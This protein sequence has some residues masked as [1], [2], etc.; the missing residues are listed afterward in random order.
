MPK[1]KELTIEQKLKLLTGKNMWQTEDFE[2]DID[3]IFMSDGPHGI[4]KMD[5]I[6][7]VII[8][9]YRET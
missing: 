7:A 1:A 3:S 4:R 5:K 6:V 2:G 9:K 8:G